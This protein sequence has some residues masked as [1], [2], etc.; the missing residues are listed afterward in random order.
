MGSRERSE[1]VGSGFVA[2]VVVY[3]SGVGGMPWSRR[4]RGSNFGMPEDSASEVSVGS[5]RIGSVLSLLL[6]I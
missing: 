4:V 3:W 6:G 1:D 2:R 5:G